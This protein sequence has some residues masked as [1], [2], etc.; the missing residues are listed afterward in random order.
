MLKFGAIW[1]CISGRF[2]RSWGSEISTELDIFFYIY[3]EK[4]GF[5]SRLFSAY[6]YIKKQGKD[7]QKHGVW[8]LKN[9]WGLEKWV[10]AGFHIFVSL[11]ISLRNFLWFVVEGELGLRP[12]CY[13][14]CSAFHYF[15]SQ[16]GKAF[17][18]FLCISLIFNVTEI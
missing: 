13:P 14:F 12:S 4:N 2:W 11:V 15:I 1:F 5:G 18:N 9:Y 6:L 3:M 7:S 16:L 17:L 10:L 8:L